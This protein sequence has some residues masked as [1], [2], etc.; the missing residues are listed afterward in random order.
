MK[1]TRVQR[2]PCGSPESDSQHITAENVSRSPRSAGSAWAREKRF[3]SV[4]GRRMAYMGEGRPTTNACRNCSLKNRCT[5]GPA[6]PH[7][8]LG[9]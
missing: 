1:A 3:A 5:P 4:L 9:A 7:H 2:E 8:A 6:V